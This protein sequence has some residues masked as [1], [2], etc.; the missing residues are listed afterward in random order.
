VGDVIERGEPDDVEA[1]VCTDVAVSHEVQEL[2]SAAC[3]E[4]FEFVVANR[5]DF[6]PL[7]DFAVSR[8]GHDVSPVRRWARALIGVIQT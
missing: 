8:H 3:G 2:A 6:D 7:D 5:N 4:A 1:A